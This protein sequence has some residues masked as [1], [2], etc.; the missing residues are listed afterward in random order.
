MK[1]VTLENIYDTLLNETP[2]VAL[3]EDVRAKAEKSIR[4]MLDMSF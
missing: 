3:D 2:E 4:A 1:L